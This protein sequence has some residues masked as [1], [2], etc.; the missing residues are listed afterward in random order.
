MGNIKES[1]FGSCI[2]EQ[3]N[4]NAI[5]GLENRDPRNSTARWER[6]QNDSWTHWYKNRIGQDRNQ[7]DA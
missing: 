1:V 2:I 4:T 3:I 6:Y 5:L 7:E